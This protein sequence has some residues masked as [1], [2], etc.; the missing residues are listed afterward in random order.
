MTQGAAIIGVAPWLQTPAG[1]YLLE[2]EQAQLDH[3]VVDLFG[4]HAVQLGWPFAQAL[5][6]NRMP[7]RWMLSD[8]RFDPEGPLAEMAGT[9][10]GGAGAAAG[11]AVPGEPRPATDKSAGPRRVTLLS[12]FDALPFPAQSLD[13]VVLPHTLEMA[14]DAHHTLREVERVLVPE[15]RV[16]VIGFNPTSLWGLRQRFGRLGGSLGLGSLFLPEANSLIGYW[17][18]RDWLKL[19]SF[20]IEAGRFG[21]YRPA[22]HSQKWM[23]RLAWMDKTGDRWW[24]VLGAVYMLV[25]VKRVRG[26]RLIGLARKKKATAPAAPAV[27]A[28]R[29]GHASRQAAAWLHDLEPLPPQQTSTRTPSE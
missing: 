21:C 3:A 8:G 6:A 20:E 18:L 7:H 25:A 27:V 2:W 29:H 23:D 12:E 1:R 28:N 16:V 11:E 10:A 19:L 24:P 9:P 26:M 13:L 22:L 15:G 4:F 17:R 5:R 14:R